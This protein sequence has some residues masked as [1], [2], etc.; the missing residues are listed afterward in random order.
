AQPTLARIGPEIA[1]ARYK[2]ASQYHKGGDTVVDVACGCGFGSRFF[3]MA[4]KYIGIDLSNPIRAVIEKGKY[5]NDRTE[6][7][8]CNI[9]SD[10][11]PLENL[12]DVVVSMETIE[13][14][15]YPEK[16]QHTLYH[17]VKPNGT[18]V[19]STPNNPNTF[20][21][22]H[23]PDYDYHV[24]EFSIEEMRGYLNNA[25]F[26]IQEEYANG[27]LFGLFLGIMR[28]LGHKVR[29]KRTSAQRSRLSLIS[30][31]LKFV[32]D[33]YNTYVPYRYLGV[34]GAG[35]MIVAKKPS[36]QTQS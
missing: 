18:L 19:I 4:A 8:G 36:L 30:D 35:L 7:I 22:T 1:K 26:E 13:H 14:L 10:K 15:I 3:P 9:D 34:T 28:K 20:W 33:I 21:H 6:F 12:A 11:P 31:H 25:G 29:R 5:V 24:Q 32:R 27:L 2:F 17:M 16:F 23:K